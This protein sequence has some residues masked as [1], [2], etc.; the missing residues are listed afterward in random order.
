MTG[1][2]IDGGGVSIRLGYSRMG[3]QLFQ[4]TFMTVAAGAGCT[5]S[6]SDSAC[7]CMLGSII[8][9]HFNHDGITE[10]MAKSAGC[11]GIFAIGSLAP[12]GP[13]G[14]S[15]VQPMKIKLETAMTMIPDKINWNNFFIFLSVFVNNK[16]IY[17]SRQWCKILY[18]KNIEDKW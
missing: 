17:N 6:F 2:A 15:L 7:R 12:G 4:E 14:P 13:C 1:A 16:C 10:I 18:N 3:L 8:L 9:E 5:G 11:I